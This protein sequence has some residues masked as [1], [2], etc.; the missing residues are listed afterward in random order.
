MKCSLFCLA[1]L[2]SITAFSQTPFKSEIT[3]DATQKGEEISP[4]QYGQFIEHLGRA[5]TGGIYDEHSK[6]S[7]SNGFRMDVLEKVKELR[8]P[9]L[10][11][12]GGT[13][14][15]I[16]HW[17][18]GVGPKAFRKKRKNLIWGGVD[19]NHF[20][21]AEFIAYCRKIG[22][23][24]F[25]V[26]NMA[27]G[28][29]EE[30]ANWVEYCNGT[31]DTYYANLRRKDGF[32]KPFNVKYWGIGNEEGAEPDMGRHQNVDQYIK[33]TWQFVKMMKL[34][35]SSL[36]LILVGNSDDLSWS[37]TV[38]ARLGPICDYLSIHLYS[39]PADTTFSSLIQSIDRIEQPLT[40]V[41]SLL[42]ATPVKVENFSPWYRFPPRSEQ[43]KI[44]VDEWGIWDI[45]S[46]K[47]K[48]AYRLEYQ[49][50]WMHALGV[51]T[52]LNLFQ[53]HSGSIGMATWAQTVNVLAPIMSDSAGSYRQTIFAPLQAFRDYTGKYNLP[54]QATT[55][56]SSPGIKAIDAASS[57]SADGHQIILTLVNRDVDHSIETVVH[58]KNHQQNGQRVTLKQISYTGKSLYGVNSATHENTVIKTQIKKNVDPTDFKIVLSPASF[59]VIVLNGL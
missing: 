55:H 31:T 24:P 17:E 48:G 3:I 7:D 27:T 21:T 5:I 56:Q 36:K 30:A 46:G 53:R 47:G 2:L 15:K 40:Q 10:R 33:D 52:F 51:A 11:Y 23:E 18:D 1:C 59:V 34:Q 57:R 44:A 37:R 43:V 50:N 45:N 6:L 26:V 20:G 29:P 14:T 4:L 12:P 22:A 32:E 35:D 42:A 54:T 9:L 25:L 28:T 41:D 38:L 19:D 39:I 49:Y 8:T 58:V 13:F 16:Y